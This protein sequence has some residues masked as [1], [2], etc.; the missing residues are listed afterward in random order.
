MRYGMMSNFR[1]SWSVV[2]MRAVLPQKQAFDNSYLFTAISPLSGDS[3][4]L[5]GFD[6]MNTD[7]EYIFLTE[8]KKQHPDQHIIVVMDNA[9]CH[10]SLILHMIEG[11]TVIKLPPYSPELNP[12]ERFFE[13][14]RRSTANEI[15]DTLEAIEER[16]TQAVNDWT[17]EKL[18]QLTCYEWIREQ[19]GRVS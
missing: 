13:E 7:A 18:K 11:L 9:P 3:F 1:R 12:V 10:R 16:I 19:V 5:L 8:L 6:D 14:I 15:F 17:K 2:G 4:H